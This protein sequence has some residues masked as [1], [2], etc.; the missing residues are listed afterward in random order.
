ML[1]NIKTVKHKG[2]KLLGG[3]AFMDIQNISNNSPVIYKPTH[4]I[5]DKKVPKY[6]F[7]K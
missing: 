6:D 5:H 4:E 3:L 1:R 7:G 2:P